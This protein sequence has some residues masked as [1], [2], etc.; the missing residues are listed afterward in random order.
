MHPGFYQNAKAQIL[1]A[2]KSHAAF[3]PPQGPLASPSTAAPGPSQ[4]QGPPR[5]RE[6]SAFQPPSTPLQSFPSQLATPAAQQDSSAAASSHWAAAGGIDL[7]AEEEALRANETQFG[8][9]VPSSAPYATATSAAVSMQRSAAH[10]HSPYL[11]LYPLA[12]TVY[13]TAS[14]HGLGDVEPEVLNA[15]SSAARIRFRNLLEEMVKATRHRCWSTH[16]REPPMHVRDDEDDEGHEGDNVDGTENKK[17]KGKPLYREDLLSDPSKWLTAIERAE[18]GEEAVMRRRRIH[19]REMREKAAAAAAAAGAASTDGPQASSGGGA[20]GPIAAGSGDGVG[21]EDAPMDGDDHNQNGQRNKRPRKDASASMTAKNMSEDVRRRLANNTAARA[22][23]GI[24]GTMPKW[25]MMSGSAAAANTPVKSFGAGKKEGTA[26]GVGGSEDSPMGSSTPS[27]LPKPRFAPTNGGGPGAWAKA[28]AVSGLAP[29]GLSGSP[30]PKHGD[31]QSTS[32][33]ID[34]QGWGDPALR[35][36][37]KEEER[38]QR[39][40]RVNLDDAM[41]ALEMERRGN[42]GGR[43][44]GQKTLYQWRMLR[45][46]SLGPAGGEGA[47][48]GGGPARAPT[49]RR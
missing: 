14:Q 26:D 29:S 45:S 23:G 31:G 15:L 30:L 5:K 43:G 46:S 19:L 12:Q 44:S 38:R 32:R 33:S 40:Q 10:G 6:P 8:P 37:A 18:R 49:G 36:L 41:H 11:Q 24:G 47:S 21:G 39:S 2:S 20:E 3:R 9:G 48:H 35:A 16:L 22:L 25:M 7:R 4:P 42:A 13:R 1:Q 17:R 27:S 28:G 34:P